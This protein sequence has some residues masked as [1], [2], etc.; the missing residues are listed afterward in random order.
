M[1]AAL[2]IG[3]AAPL[4]AEQLLADVRRAWNQKHTAEANLARLRTY[5]HHTPGMKSDADRYLRQL[6]SANSTLKRVLGGAGMTTERID[7]LAVMDE[8]I[9]CYGSVEECQ[10]DT[11]FLEAAR[12]AR[13]AVAELIEAAI[14]AHDF[15]ANTARN[16]G[17]ELDRRF[18]R[19][20]AALVRVGAP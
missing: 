16:E 2:Q 14:D 19:L 12:E 15:A 10:D 8:M 17:R 1:S 3:T 9:D 6:E 20:R 5:R 13:A 7:V 4:T 18:Y 11:E